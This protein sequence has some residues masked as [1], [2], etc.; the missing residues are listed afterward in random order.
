MKSSPVL[1]LIIIACGLNPLARGQSVPSLINYQGRLTDQTG[2]PQAA[3]TYTIQFRLWD[4][5]GNATGLIWAQQQ[6][7]TVQANGVFNVILG[8]PGGTSILNPLPMVN[9]LA[10]AFT[11]SNR[12]LGLTVVSNSGSATPMPSEILP[13]QQFL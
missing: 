7:V 11:S 12:F 13:R 5:P 1:L 4:S 9:D 6:N 3:S 2:A 8:A 10:F